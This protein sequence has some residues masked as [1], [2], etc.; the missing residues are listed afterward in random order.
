MPSHYT[1]KRQTVGNQNSKR[2]DTLFLFI[3][4]C[5]AATGNGGLEGG[6]YTYQRD[7]HDDR[8][9]SHGLLLL[10]C[11]VRTTSKKETKD[12]VLCM[13]NSMSSL[14]SCNFSVKVVV[15]TCLSFLLSFW[16]FFL[17]YR[18]CCCCCWCCC[19]YSLTDQGIFPI[20]RPHD[21][22]PYCPLA[23]ISDYTSVIS[24]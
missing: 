22:L 9:E 20:M 3:S 14:I 7:L 13:I 5:H 10:V 4:F 11:L 17:S 2:H 24:G 1:P 15:M 6:I 18:C 12:I 8:H 21:V 19:Y 16:F 23:T